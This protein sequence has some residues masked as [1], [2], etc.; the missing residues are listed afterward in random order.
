MALVD[1]II[2]VFN[3]RLQFVVAALSSLRE[4]TFSDWK[5]WVIDDGSDAE[6]GIK[7]AETLR[8]FDDRRIEYLYSDHQGISASRNVAI[9]KGRAPYIA[10]LDSDDCW[11]PDHLSNHVKILDANDAITLTHG[12]F[13]IIDSDGQTLKSKPAVEGLNSLNFSQCFVRMLIENFVAFS[14][15]V[16]RRSAVEQIEG[17]DGTFPCL[18]D[19][20][21]LLRLLNAGAKF[22]HDPAA[23]LQYRV[24]PQNISKK[25]DLLFTTRRRLIDLAEKFIQSNP[26]LGDI[27]WPSLKKEMERHR[28][29]EAAEAHFAQHRYTEAL[30][31]GSPL[32][33]GL[34]RRSCMLFL[35]SLARSIA[36]P[37]HR[38]NSHTLP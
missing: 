38:A 34:S 3:T 19:K 17:F 15:V 8:S 29:K 26:L 7:L 31:Y 11:M 12:H 13:S 14:S 27:D 10:F 25:T 4:Q 37:G 5:S 36:S 35:R 21:F 9:M 18:S 23:A 30:K 1:V 32:H 20:V 6:Y 22:H 16:V 24:H 2:P 33:S 28:Y